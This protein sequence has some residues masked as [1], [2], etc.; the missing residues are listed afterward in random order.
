VIRGLEKLK[1]EGYLIG[2]AGNK[3]EALA[4]ADRCAGLILGLVF[5]VLSS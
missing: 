3:M 2:G 5:F 1:K 4:E